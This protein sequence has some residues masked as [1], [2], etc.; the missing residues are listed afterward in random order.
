MSGAWVEDDDADDSADRQPL[1]KELSV[2]SQGSDFVGDI[3]ELTAT[4]ASLSHRDSDGQESPSRLDDQRQDEDVARRGSMPQSSRTMDSD[5][6]MTPLTLRT[7][8]GPHLDGRSQEVHAVDV[9]SWVRPE[10]IFLY[11]PAHETSS[12]GL[13]K[14]ETV[15]TSLH[16]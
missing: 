13:V 4:R 16:P 15:N 10:Q 5:R 12:A 9:V 6:P 11:Y 1:V 2:L 3:T 14:I 7:H 8:A